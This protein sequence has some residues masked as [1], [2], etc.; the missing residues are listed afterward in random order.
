[1]HINWKPLRLLYRA[2]FA[3]AGRARDAVLVQSER[4]GGKVRHKSVARLGTLT[5]WDVAGHMSQALERRA[6]SVLD[7]E[8]TGPGRGTFKSREGRSQFRAFC[9]AGAALD[10]LHARDNGEVSSY[11]DATGSFLFEP[12]LKI[13]SPAGEHARLVG[14]LEAFVSKFVGRKVKRPCDQ[15]RARPEAPRLKLSP[16][17]GSGARRDARCSRSE[18]PAATLTNRPACALGV[19]WRSDLESARAP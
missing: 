1:M 6:R 18:D 4:R 15:R 5:R 13:Y 8:D 7:A 10:R 2:E 19:L 9:V 17:E 3:Q 16:K 12:A 11:G 14:K